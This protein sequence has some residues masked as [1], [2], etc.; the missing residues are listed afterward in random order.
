MDQIQI[1]DTT[2]FAT[3]SDDEP[4]GR[5]KHVLLTTHLKNRMSRFAPSTFEMGPIRLFA[6]FSPA[7]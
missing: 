5:R 7:I 1:Q 4:M 2:I 6:A 3:E